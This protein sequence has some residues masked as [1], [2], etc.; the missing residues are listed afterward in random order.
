MVE[1]I[2]GP[3]KLVTLDENDY[4]T[5]GTITQFIGSTVNEKSAIKLATIIWACKRLATIL[6]MTVTFCVMCVCILWSV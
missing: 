5:L 2:T 3:P 4:Q 6:K 1:Q